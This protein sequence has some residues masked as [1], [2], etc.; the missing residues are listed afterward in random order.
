MR[1][2]VLAFDNMLGGLAAGIQFPMAFRISVG[3]IE[4]W[5]IKNASPMGV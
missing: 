5:M 1:K 2:R 4:D 3:G